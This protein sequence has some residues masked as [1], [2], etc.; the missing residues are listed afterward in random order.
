MRSIEEIN[1]KYAP[2]KFEKLA[3]TEFGIALWEFLKKKET[4]IRM[5]TASRLKRAAVEGIAQELEIL[6]PDELKEL[7]NSTYFLRCKQMIGHMIRQI[8]DYHEYEICMRNV[9]VVSPGIFSK[10]TRYKLKKLVAVNYSKHVPK[11]ESL[12]VITENKNLLDGLEKISSKHEITLNVRKQ[13]TLNILEDLYTAT[14][15][16]LIIDPELI[17]EGTYNDLLSW[18]NDLRV[19]YLD[20][21][22]N[23]KMSCLEDFFDKD[24]EKNLVIGPRF[25]CDL[26]KRSYVE[27]LSFIDNYY[28]GVDN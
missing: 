24:I 4:F 7:K 23:E 6:F 3:S 19:D 26:S 18:F 8:M 13:S 1:M 2:W 15:D 28:L 9:R 12:L 22:D 20:L 5:Q 27:V 17:T 25:L 21:L 11:Y 10:G 16:G 14:C